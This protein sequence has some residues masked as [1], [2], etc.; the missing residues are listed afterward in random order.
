M[1][2][3][4]HTADIF[5]IFQENMEKINRVVD[6]IV[7]SGIFRKDINKQLKDFSSLGKTML[8]AVN[9]IDIIC[10]AIFKI[11][12][13]LS[14]VKPLSESSLI[15]LDSLPPLWDKLNELREAELRFLN[16]PRISHGKM[17]RKIRNLFKSYIYLMIGAVDIGSFMMTGTIPRN[18]M[19]GRLGQQLGLTRDR[20]YDR[21]EIVQ[22]LILTSVVSKLLGSIFRDMQ[23]VFEY[24]S[25]AGNRASSTTAGL[26][27][28]NMLFISSS[29]K[30]LLGFK[31]SN[32]PSLIETFMSIFVDTLSDS[33]NPR[34]LSGKEIVYRWSIIRL[35]AF[36]LA[37]IFKTLEPVMNTLSDI[38]DRKSSIVS[39]LH[40]LNVMLVSSKKKSV[41]G[42]TKQEAIPSIIESVTSIIDTTG[43]L[44]A[45]DVA[46]IGTGV[47]SLWG[48]ST[49]LSKIANNIAQI[50][51]NDKSITRGLRAIS[52]ILIGVERKRFLGFTTRGAIPSLIDSIRSLTST[53]E[54]VSV[55][56]IG[57]ITVS[58]S[59]LYGSSILL[60][61]T[62]LEISRIGQNRESITDGLKALSMMLYGREKKFLRTPVPSLIEDM[63][64]I[65]DQKLTGG[66]IGSIIKVAVS[67]TAF[68][69][70]MMIAGVGISNIGQHKRRIKR[71]LKVM[72]KM[73]MSYIDMIDLVI[74]NDKLSQAEIQK[75]A[76][77]VTVLMWKLL[78][79]VVPAVFIGVFSLGLVFAMR[80]VRSIKKVVLSTI[81]LIVETMSVLEKNNLIDSDG[82]LSQRYNAAYDATLKVIQG[83][84]QV[85]L[86]IVKTLNIPA[87]EP[88]KFIPKLVGLGFMITSLIG[89]TISMGVLFLTLRAMGFVER[90]SG[91]TTIDGKPS[92]TFKVSTRLISTV[93]SVKYMIDGLSEVASKLKVIQPIADSLRI[94]A[95]MY[96][97]AA[98]EVI[99]VLSGVIYL[100]LRA[101]GLIEANPSDSGKKFTVSTRLTS[102]MDSIKLIITGLVETAEGLKTLNIIVA[103]L[104][105]ATLM[106][107]VAEM[108]VV[109]GLVS[110][111]G[112][113]P[114]K[115]VERGIENIRKVT[116]IVGELIV[117][118]GLMAIT[119]LLGLL[120]S[121]PGLLTFALGMTIISATILMITGVIWII[122]RIP[123]GI[124]ALGTA[125]IVLLAV[126][127]TFILI[128]KSL[129]VIA[130]IAENINL[131]SISNIVDCMANG[132]LAFIRNIKVLNPITLAMSIATTTA[133]MGLMVEISIIAVLMKR[134][135]SLSIPIAFDRK[136]RPIAYEQ[137]REED[138]E[139]ATHV[140]NLIM[141]TIPNVLSQTSDINRRKLSNSIGATRK[142]R[143]VVKNI[144]QMA[145][146]LRDLAS[147]RFA[148]EWNENGRPI[149][150]TTMTS[151]DFLM[152]GQNAIG[153]M[154][155]FTSLMSDGTHSIKFA[156]T[157]VTIQGIS[158]DDLD[159][160]S[161]KS[162]RKV[163][164]L[165]R[166]VKNIGNMSKVLTDMANLKFT[167][168]WSE[169]GK[170]KSYEQMT[171]SH[172]LTASLN[173]AGILQ[174]FV[175]LM[176]PGSHSL[177][178]SGGK[179]NITGIDTEALK[180]IKRKTKKHVR[181]VN[182]IVSFIGD[183]AETLNNL[184]SL[185]IATKWNSNGKPVEFRELSSKD[186]KYA[187]TT[188]EALL[189]YFSKL[190]TPGKH[191]FS[192][193]GG[194]VAFD[195][196]DL[197][198]VDISKSNKKN[199]KRI[200]D[201]VGSIG[202]ISETISNLAHLKIADSIDPKTGAATG[203]REMTAEDFKSATN[204]TKLLID[205]ICQIPYMIN[206]SM[207]VYGFDKK[208]KIKDYTDRIGN[209]N[210]LLN[211]VI[212]ISTRLHKLSDNKLQQSMDDLSSLTYKGI[213]GGTY[214]GLKSIQ[215]LISGMI[216]VC[217]GV[218]EYLGNYSIDSVKSQ[219]KEIRNIWK[220]TT[221]I[222]LSIRVDKFV[223]IIN[224]LNG[225]RYKSI[226]E[227]TYNGVRGIYQ[228]I[229]D[230]SSMGVKISESIGRSRIDSTVR[231]MG[232]LRTIWTRASY[233]VRDLS[234]MNDNSA[235]AAV[236]SIESTIN[237]FK[238]V[239]STDTNKL[240]YAHSL[241]Y[242]IAKLS[243]SI[244]GNFDRLADV[245][246]EKLIKAI[247]ELNQLLSD[248]GG[249]N[250]S[251][252][253]TID[254][255]SLVDKNKTKIDTSNTNYL[256][257]EL[258]DLQR[259]ISMITRNL[260]TLA[261]CVDNNSSRNS[262]RVKKI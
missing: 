174:F 9:Q 247:E 178:M 43:G 32:I 135:A 238:Q 76:N 200:S 245:I 65:R 20:R 173:A 241:V 123:G 208:D 116:I 130:E 203:W 8:V 223:D 104:S 34:T 111:I 248:M 93:D 216:R 259:S 179:V 70:L 94:T 166:I 151:V 193:M 239:N 63:L 87:L 88:K 258:D 209:L 224:Q 105:A 137:M 176:T 139:R 14:V 74:N 89:T 156:G 82:K 4:P 6:L 98:C 28:L 170:P 126:S 79:A 183:M 5:D 45:K 58:L 197:N 54:G 150:F 84:A 27:A 159:N 202:N 117:T 148:T 119:A 165:Y 85:A 155:M 90:S 127:L 210:Q 211:P 240:K 10:S 67:I 199:I 161:R 15:A 106:V 37:G 251:H 19:I 69:S 22:G 118:A 122:N 108:V 158:S 31:R 100:S 17:R 36:N 11:E 261:G 41:L 257:K 147:L 168:S 157:A 42:F 39:G 99:V 232:A 115:V 180:N 81:D 134:I 220:D 91:E 172:F 7:G 255:N 92:K 206:Q 222:P 59:I 40:S 86:T 186:F 236:R 80:V 109:V 30:R 175:K 249:V 221:K 184:A 254:A 177:Q 101:L 234:N 187:S 95:L 214:R 219:I 252:K 124:L 256:K 128:A 250:I 171:A 201:I 191:S 96:F 47:A 207:S 26:R 1:S 143:R 217:I 66:E 51:E 50:G 138:F 83:Q 13:S 218:S 154:Q 146:T 194:S 144:G 131:N 125:M 262:I 226:S 38:G 192:F 114:E 21:K 190:L 55:A 33:R 237:L 75:G 132:V 253:P 225:V 120:I 140:T 71:G 185:R 229:L 260:N 153:V 242:D 56:D 204:N 2:K 133:M 160:I 230:V 110:L 52:T 149:K 244:N 103:T 49:V 167:T 121:I 112:L 162:K 212:N 23:P 235:A 129:K 246:N 195:G 62:A 44:K 107:F 181:R 61:A 152:A 227:N 57:R 196:I 228:M 16:G 189:R 141:S 60:R 213:D 3:I 29:E 145:E 68:S 163:Q 243:E 113:I 231:D 188:A 164:N 24:M 78:A 215:V 142:I 102:T 48:I 77:V 136:G 53:T 233:M 35:F 64:Y 73:I 18:T 198:G 72:P 25:S 205:T 46:W 12:K 169:D 97:S 182:K